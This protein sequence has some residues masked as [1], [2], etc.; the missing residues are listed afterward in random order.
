MSRERSANRLYGLHLAVALAGAA[1]VVG[2]LAFVVAGADFSPPSPGSV[3][4]ACDRWLSAGGPAAS[5][6]LAVG[7]LALAS[8][9]LGLRSVRRQL[10]ASRRYLLGLP[11]SE[12]VVAVEGTACRLIDADTPL[13]FC[14]GY[15]KPQ[16][17]VSRGA[18]SDLRAD[19]LRAVVSHE[20]HHV[21]RRDPLR[22]LLARSLAD[23][24]FFVPLLRRSSE[25]YVALGELAADEAAVKGLNGR[26]PL[27]SA[28]LKFSE[29]G[30]QPATVL[31]IAPERV[32]HL[33]GDPAAGRWQ[34]PRFL[35]G[36]SAVALLGLA[37]LFGAAAHGLFM[38]KLDLPALLSAGCM[39]VMIGGPIALAVGATLLSRR[40]LRA[41]RL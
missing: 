22:L 24:L 32:D 18:L 36:S 28:L 2:T 34:L 1:L 33:M 37:A 6:A 12:E 17:F 19:E 31:G 27:A 35:A 7:A 30:A 3:A 13:A 9:W 10:K 21:R 20:L 25:R 26:G 14:A 16:I 39:V 15:L 8:L 40:T 4:A 11:I 23:G 38:S 41:R 5:V 29:S